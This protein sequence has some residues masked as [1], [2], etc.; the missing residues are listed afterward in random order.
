MC[1][2]ARAAAIVVLGIGATSA[3]AVV[4]GIDGDYHEVEMPAPP[5]VAP[6]DSGDPSLRLERDGGE[7]DAGDAAEGAPD[8]DAG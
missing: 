4:L 5:P 6:L 1:G 7:S 2:I 3:C 8:R